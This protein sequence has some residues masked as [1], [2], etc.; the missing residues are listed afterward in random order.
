MSTHST[1]RD[2]LTERQAREILDAALAAWNSR[3]LRALA[4]FYTPDITYWM[5]WGGPDNGPR[6]IS[7]RQE[8]IR[9][10]AEIRDTTESVIEVSRS[11]L[12]GNALKAHFDVRWRDRQTGLTHLSTCRQTLYFSGNRFCRI[13]EF[14]DGA[15]LQAFRSLSLGRGK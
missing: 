3:N 6:E 2:Q 9:N 7:G 15:A 4:E 13:E 11:R 14:Q 12:E 1:A 5:N 10:F 8:L